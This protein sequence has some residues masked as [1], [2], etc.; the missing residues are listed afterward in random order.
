[1]LKR[2]KA[3]HESDRM[4]QNQDTEGSESWILQENADGLRSD[5]SD[6]QG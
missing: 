2:H 5:G 4:H 3:V 6:R 1:M